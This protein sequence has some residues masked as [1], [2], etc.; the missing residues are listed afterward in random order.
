MVKIFVHTLVMPAPSAEE[1]ALSSNFANFSAYYKEQ[2][3]LDPSEY[4]EMV[5]TVLK[6][7][8][9]TFRL[10]GVLCKDRACQESAQAASDTF[11]A[12]LVDLIGEPRLVS[13]NSGS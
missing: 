2:L 13:L 7:L 8:P 11:H 10:V 3:R 12:R 6:P 4:A 1:I 9:I 5:S